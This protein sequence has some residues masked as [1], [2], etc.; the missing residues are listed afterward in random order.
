[1][2]LFS[3]T[4]DPAPTP[5]PVGPTEDKRAA[6]TE[7]I[8]SLDAESVTLSHRLHPRVPPNASPS[9][10]AERARWFERQREISD[11]KRFLQG[12]LDAIERPSR[13]AAARRAKRINEIR[14]FLPGWQAQLKE[15]NHRVGLAQQQAAQQQS[16]AAGIQERID[17]LE[18]ELASL[19]SGC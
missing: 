17:R 13:D 11:R 3:S 9:L 2:R 6:I 12:E 16:V 8:A 4:P 10:L 1:M 5:T 19:T 15:A 7:E 14:F 18:A